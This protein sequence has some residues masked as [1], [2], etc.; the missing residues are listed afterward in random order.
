LP[1]TL[2]ICQSTLK[3]LSCCING[4]EFSITAGNR[5]AQVNWT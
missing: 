5:E 2:K 1:M 3:S 4:L